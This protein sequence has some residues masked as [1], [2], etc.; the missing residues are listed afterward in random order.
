MIRVKNS[1][2]GSTGLLQ[3]M[4]DVACLG[5]R[6]VAARDVSHACCSCEVAELV[7]PPVVQD[8]DLQFFCGI[9]Q[10][11]RRQHRGSYY[12]QR[13]VVSGNEDVHR[14]PVAGIPGQWHGPSLQRSQGLEV[15]EN[16]RG[17]RVDVGQQ[18]KEHEYRMP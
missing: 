2:A 13:L 8:E 7:A 5:V 14:W 9:V 6:I 17:K 11:E 4:I 10:G 1:N 3:G 16:Q 12:T 15:P 18:Q